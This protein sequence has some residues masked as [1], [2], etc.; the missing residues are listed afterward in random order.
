MQM[1]INIINIR[2]FFQ[3]FLATSCQTPHSALL[4]VGLKSGIPSEFA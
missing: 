4:H 2:S 1:M 3:N